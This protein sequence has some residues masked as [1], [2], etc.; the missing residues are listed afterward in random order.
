MSFFHRVRF[1]IYQNNKC[2]IMECGNRT[3]HDFFIWKFLNIRKS[4]TVFCKHNQDCVNIKSYGYL[5]TV[6][7]KLL[8]FCSFEHAQFHTE[9]GVWHH[10]YIISWVLFSLTKQ[11]RS[12]SLVTWSIFRSLW[13]G[14]KRTQHML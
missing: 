4:F 6:K 7:P 1:G 13:L 11:R 8:I 10:I 9:A 5:E 12:P 3:K 2:Q 14:L